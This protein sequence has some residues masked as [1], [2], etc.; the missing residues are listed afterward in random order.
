MPSIFSVNIKDNVFRS[1]RGTST[2]ASFRGNIGIYAVTKGFFDFEVNNNEFTNLNCGILINELTNSAINIDGVVNINNNTMQ[3]THPN[4]IATGTESFNTG[5]LFNGASAVQYINTMNFRNNNMVNVSRG[6]G[7]SKLQNKDFNIIGNTISVANSPLASIQ[8]N[9]YGIGL[10]SGNTKSALGGIVQGNTIIGNCRSCKLT[11]I[12]LEQQSNTNLGCNITGQSTSNQ[13]I[14]GLTHGFRFN[15]KNTPTQFYDNMMYPTNQNGMTVENIGIIG[16][17]GSQK[18]LGSK[19]NCTS[20]NSWGAPVSTWTAWGRNNTRVDNSSLFNANTG[21]FN[22]QLIVRNSTS[23]WMNPDGGGFKIGIIS[24]IP[25]Q[26]ST[27]PLKSSIVIGINDA[28]CTTA[29]CIPTVKMGARFSENDLDIMK[30]IATGDIEI[31][32]DDSEQRLY[33]MQEKLYADLKDNEPIIN[34]EETLRI[35]LQNNQWNSYDFIYYT[36]R[37]LEAEN[38]AAVDIMLDY[39]PSNNIVDDNY[40]LYYDWVN[41]M[42]KDESYT[43]PLNDVLTLAN[44]CPDKYGSVVYDARNL[45]MRL[46]E[47]V[48]YFETNCESQPASR[49]AKPNKTRIANS[50][51]LNTNIV[52]FPNPSN[53]IININMP[54]LSKGDWKISITDVYGKIVQQKQLQNG[55]INQQF[56][57]AI[58]GMYFI[59]ITDTKTGKQEVSKFVIN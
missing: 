27:N 9:Q 32:Y 33:V 43:P 22:S 40:Y 34:D 10:I 38:N 55:T 44:Q 58:K 15:G 5:I 49:Q 39:F 21:K 53:G 29:R 13:A 12:Y 24:P 59:T 17:Q 52:V 3:A 57:I 8:T 47:D 23:G 28:S 36:K 48:Y 19:S 37:Y 56:N 2:G 26:T 20:D 51:K 18:A 41:Q 50:N 14:E 31:P 25:F 42:Q 54:L 4:I 35:F 11:G 16:I 1:T 7:L 30:D 46:I 6:I 45:Y